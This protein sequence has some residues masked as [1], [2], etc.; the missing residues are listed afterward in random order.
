M[1]RCKI[2]IEHSTYPPFKLHIRPN[3]LVSDVLAYLNLPKEDYI[4]YPVSDPSKTLIPKDVLY[5]LI[6]SDAKLIARLS[7]QAEAKYAQLFMQ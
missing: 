2:R 6:D 4:I 7:P 1:K 5:D 3:T